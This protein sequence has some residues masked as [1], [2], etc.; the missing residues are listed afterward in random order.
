MKK[1]A[2]WMTLILI[3]LFGSTAVSTHAQSPNGL[4]A[5]VPFDFI[6]GDKTLHAGKI[7][8]GGM[9]QSA[10]G[11]TS[12]SNLSNGEHAFRIG[13]RVLSSAPSDQAKLVFHKYGSRYY[14]AQVWIPGYKAWELVPSVS[15]KNEMRLARNSQ[16][17]VVNVVADGQ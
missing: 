5:N 15:E 11:P 8:V 6:I 13:R 2:L 17:E 12:I 10:A 7:T 16:P 3:A 9:T 1:H 4:R 14:L